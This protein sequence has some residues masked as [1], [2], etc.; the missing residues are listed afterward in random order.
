MMMITLFRLLRARRCELNC[1]YSDVPADGPTSSPWKSQ[2]KRPMQ[3]ER[4]VSGATDPWR[5]HSGHNSAPPTPQR[6]PR[7][8]NAL[9]D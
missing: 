7:E 8:M 2:G 1:R 5:K 6:R 9:L 3:F 4:K